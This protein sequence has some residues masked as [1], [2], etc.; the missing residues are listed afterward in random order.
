[1]MGAIEEP[2][3]EIFGKRSDAGPQDK[4]TSERVLSVRWWTPT[5]VSI[6]HHT[7]SRL[8]VHAGALHPTRARRC[9]LG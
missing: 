7:L 6:P 1:M 2:G 3:L 9:G 4:W 8:P 5:L